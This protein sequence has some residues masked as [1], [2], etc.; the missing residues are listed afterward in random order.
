MNI[1]DKI[2][3]EN[4]RITKYLDGIREG[5]DY[6]LGDARNFDESL[7]EEALERLEEID[8][9]LYEALEILFNMVD[10]YGLDGEMEEE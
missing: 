6:E 8:E 10:D 2:F 3:E 9:K 4:G 5:L 7:K 1:D